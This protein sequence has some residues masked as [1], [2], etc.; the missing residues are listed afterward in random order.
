MSSQRFVLA[1][2]SLPG[3]APTATGEQQRLQFD[4]Q[5]PTASAQLLALICPHVTVSVTDSS[6]RLDASSAPTAS[7]K[8]QKQQQ[9]LSPCSPPSHQQAYGSQG[10]QHSRFQPSTQHSSNRH[11]VKEQGQVD[12]TGSLA[13]ESIGG[14]RRRVYMP[15]NGVDLSRESLAWQGFDIVDERQT[16][17]D[18]FHALVHAY[19]LPNGFPDSVAPQYAPYMFWRG[20]QYFFGGAMSVFTT[21]SLLGALGVAGRYSGEA[22]A[23]INWVIKD[24]AGRLGR[25]LFARWGRELDCELKQFRLF[26]DLLMEAGAALELATVYAPPAFLPLAC[27]A[28]LAKN[29]AAVAASATRAPI[30]RTFARA[31]N[32]ADI[33][34]KGE[35]VANLADILGTVAGILLA[36]VKLPTVAT[37][38]LLSA[39]Y[40]LSSRREVDSVELPYMNRARLAYA[41]RRYLTDGC[42]PGVAEANQQEPLLPWGRYNQRRLV[43]GAS[44]EAA[45]AGPADLSYAAGLF[46]QGSYGYMV[47]YRPDT[48]KA[49][50]LLREGATSW[51]CLQASFFGHVFLHL[52]DGGRLDAEGL[53]LQPAARQA[54][55]AAAAA[56]ST[57]GGP[58]ATRPDAATRAVSSTAGARSAAS[59]GGCTGGKDAS[60]CMGRAS[61]Q[62]GSEFGPG[63]ACTAGDATAGGSECW[64]TAMVRA[65][66]VV[67]ALYPDFLAR[68]ERCGWKLQQTMLNPQESRLVRVAVP[69]Q[70]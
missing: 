37:F 9:S 68:A 67:A 39:G 20:V 10:D 60:R 41:T 29:L 48:R 42:V 64:R 58:G 16:H 65:Q 43:L 8:E 46:R 13:V 45:C 18:H 15:R 53:P 66:A 40:L 25:L 70:A 34:A 33:T 3:G 61:A 21:Q 47:T 63:R 38:T 57:V 12:D 56:P 35:S 44:V 36:R 14:R 6:G 19:L 23:A 51:D 17:E 28:N 11:V 22:S 24:G 4:W 27:T 1:S 54:L 62:A 7:P 26:G 32:L 50:V 30:Y 49:Y 59:G 31:N 2:I 5:I 55:G 69:L 52:L